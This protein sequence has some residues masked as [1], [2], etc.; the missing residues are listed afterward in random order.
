MRT[1]KDW[2]KTAYVQMNRDF[3]N[4]G[5]YC[6][7]SVTSIDFDQSDF[8]FSKGIDEES[9]GKTLKEVVERSRFLSVEEYRNVWETGKE[10]YDN[11]IKKTMKNKG[12]KTKGD[13][14][15]P[16]LHCSVEKTEKGYLFGPT[17]QRALTAWEYDDETEAN[18]FTIPLTATAAEMGAALRRC[19][20]LC[21]SK[22]DPPKNV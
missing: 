8:F 9:I 2:I 16:M 14:F 5:S 10:N 19:L 1:E 13:M 20:A 11:W 18:K 4:M 12:Y 3:I 15:K 22:F 21:T 7:Y 6:G 17:H